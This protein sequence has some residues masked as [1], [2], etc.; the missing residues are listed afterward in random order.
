MSISMFVQAKENAHVYMCAFN[1]F[2]IICFKIGDIEKPLCIYIYIYIY[3]S[4]L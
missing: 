4:S 3:W 2:K 1:I